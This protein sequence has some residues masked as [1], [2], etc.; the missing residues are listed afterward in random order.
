MILKRHIRPLAEKLAI[1]KRFGWHPFRRTFSTL[2]TGNGEDVKV[3]QEL[4]R[5][6][7]PNTT[8]ALS[9]QAI[10]E[11]VRKAQGK[12]VE[13]VRKA[14]LNS[15]KPASN[16]EFPVICARIVHRNREKA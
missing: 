8:L 13:T 7:N 6:A 16:Q 10:P 5:H 12:V 2:L 14:P 3:T 9:A 4:M 15:A 1:K 11:N